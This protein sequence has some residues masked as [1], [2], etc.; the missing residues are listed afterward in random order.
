[1]TH[2]APDIFRCSWSFLGNPWKLLLSCCNSRF[3]LA[4]VAGRRAWRLCL[5]ISAAIQPRKLGTCDVM[6]CCVM[7]VCTHCTSIY[8]IRRCGMPYVS[9]TA[10]YVTIQ[11]TIFSGTPRR[12]DLRV[13]LG[14]ILWKWLPLMGTMAI[15]KGHPYINDMI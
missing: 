14:N 3:G 10:A 9:D 15:H 2:L 5:K 1:M 13:P 12:Q 4:K 6:L 7:H 8:N 11:P